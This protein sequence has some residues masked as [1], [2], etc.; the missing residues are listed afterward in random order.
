MTRVPPP[1]LAAAFLL[2]TGCPAPHLV[3]E[4]LPPRTSVTCAAPA[5]TDPALG[6]GLLDVTAT[7]GTHGSYVADLRLSLQGQDA[8]ITGVSVSYELPEGSPKS[9]EDAAEDA[10]G[11]VVVGD[12][13]L[14]GS[15][16]DLRASVLENVELVPR[17]LALAFSDDDD[18]D[19]SDI[20]FAR[21]G[22]SITPIIDAATSTAT[23]TSS[24]FAIDLCKGCL[25]TPPSACDDDGE[26]TLNPAVCRPGQ[27]APLFFCKAAP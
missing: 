5:K 12:V 21:L 17:G 2:A 24:G 8:R 27:D 10:S 3:V 11:E 6:R 19:L 15:G 26:F 9:V 7:F 14:A 23:T 22:V 20:E 18:L 13:F 4:V 25:V 16:D 1:L